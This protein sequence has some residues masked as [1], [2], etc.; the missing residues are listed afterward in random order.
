M[1][2]R[3]VHSKEFKLEA[4]R[5]SNQPGMT[6]AKAASQLGI[7][8]TTMA[9]WKRELRADGDQAFPGHGRLKA[10]DE[11]MRKLR[12]ELKRVT[13]ERDILRKATLFFATE[14]RKR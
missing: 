9:A 8:K 7:H 11:E 4:V 12:L 3:R 6:I 13:E 10:D 1:K 5:L 14:E 2:T